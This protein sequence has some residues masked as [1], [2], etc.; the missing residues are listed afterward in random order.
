MYKAL[1]LTL[2]VSVSVWA[3]LTPEQREQLPSPADHPVDFNKEI[4][5][6][7]EAS[8]IKCHGRGK[9]KGG[10]AIDT[11]EILL[12]GGDSGAAAIPGNSKESLLI[13]MVSGLDPENVMPQKG[14]KLTAAQVGLLRAWIDQ[15]LPWE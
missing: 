3:K 9:T 1:L 8:C 11:R 10:F 4:R 15:D 2:C 14:S 5:P 13:E 12:K 7:L 6:I